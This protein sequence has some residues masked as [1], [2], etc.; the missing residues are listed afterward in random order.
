MFE[1][2]PYVPQSEVGEHLFSRDGWSGDDDDDRAQHLG[3][4]ES[5]ADVETREGL[6]KD[7]AQTDTLNRIKDSQP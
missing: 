4:G 1:P 5:R 7:H 3:E 2:V 6:E